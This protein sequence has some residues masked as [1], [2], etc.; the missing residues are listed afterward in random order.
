MIGSA[1][2]RS[3]SSTEDRAVSP[4]VGVAIAA[5]VLLVAAAGVWL[6]VLDDSGGPSVPEP[7][8]EHDER[9]VTLR[10]TAAAQSGDGVANVTQL[11]LTHTGGDALSIVQT[12]L[13]VA[14]NTSVW[15]PVPEVAWGSETISN[16]QARPE[17]DMRRTIGTDSDP[18]VEPGA[19]FHP[20]GYEGYNVNQ[21][22]DYNG[23]HFIP[24]RFT[25][26]PDTK[27]VTDEIAF[28]GAG[29][30]CHASNLYPI[31]GLS[32]G[33]RVSVAWRA[34]S[35]D[36]TQFLYNATVESGSYPYAPDELHS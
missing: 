10:D 4:L 21:L 23:Y 15:G 12:R 18:Q 29:S 7:S 17:P 9:Q 19:S 16:V 27:Q 8:F 20:I 1:V 33:Q 32:A 26:G 3:R 28:G 6:F 2:I 36:E 34:A 35:G 30:E 31:G 24:D 11:R 14:G 13:M 5:V 22:C 25:G